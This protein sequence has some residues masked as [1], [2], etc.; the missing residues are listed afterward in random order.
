M[1]PLQVKIEVEVEVRTKHQPGPPLRRLC[2]LHLLCPCTLGGAACMQPACLAMPCC[3]PDPPGGT[4]RGTAIMTGRAPCPALPG[5]LPCTAQGK[6]SDDS[7]SVE[8]EIEIEAK[9]GDRKESRELEYSV[10]L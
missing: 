7:K 6:L 2:R 10:P 1:W 5:C 4:A 3:P 9:E 8:L